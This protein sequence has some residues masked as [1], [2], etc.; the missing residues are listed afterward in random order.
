[1]H[2]KKGNKNNREEYPI[3]MKHRNTIKVSSN[4]HNLAEVNVGTLTLPFY[5]FRD[6]KGA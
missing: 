5:V 1:M 2:T 3:L 4:C 6:L